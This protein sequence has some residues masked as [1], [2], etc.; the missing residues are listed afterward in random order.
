M[1]CHIYCILLLV[2]VGL[3][4]FWRP[5]AQ[6]QQKPE[7]STVQVHLV[8]TDEAVSE[9]KE[10]PPLQLEDVKIKQ[11]KNPL[12]VTQLIPA[13]G[14]NAALQLVI[15][16]DDTLKSSVGNNLTE[17]KEFITA[18]PPSTVIAVAYMANAGVNIAQNFTPD[19]D[20]AVKAVRLPRGS[21]STMD[22]PY[23]SLISLVKSW[24]KQ[25]VRREVLIVS[26]GIDRLRGEKPELSSLGP[27]FGVVYHRPNYNRGFS[28]A[29]YRTAYE[30]SPTP[31]Y[32]SMPSISIDAPSAS[33]ISQRYNVLVYS[34]YAAG[35]GHAGRSSWDQQLGLGGLSQITDETGG[36]CFSLGT[37][38]L[39]SFKP[40]LETLQ[41]MLANQYY[42]VFEAVPKNKDGFQRVKI[43]TELSNS[44]IEAPDNVWVPS[45]AK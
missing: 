32:Q 29:S 36:E 24:P 22:S 45:A 3:P 18:Q 44:E 23:L 21:V 25:N 39:V 28:G 33:E 38:Q 9:D 40:Y 10:L 26:D 8:I 4:F 5:N 16:M 1:K 31:A 19:H 41:K 35:V 11:G 14:E 7:S 37:S 15:L 12:K 34:L 6:S 30:T 20:L 43:E 13:T 27:D 2:G 42:V 17:L